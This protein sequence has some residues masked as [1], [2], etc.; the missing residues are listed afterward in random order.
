MPRGEI[1]RREIGW[2][3]M[4]GR[5][6]GLPPYFSAEFLSPYTSCPKFY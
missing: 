3:V 4:N 6:E 5:I 2:T 1:A